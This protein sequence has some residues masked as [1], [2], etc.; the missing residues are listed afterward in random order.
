MKTLT[1]PKARLRE[2]P[3]AIPRAGQA[4]RFLVH[5]DGS[6]ASNAALRAALELAKRETEILAVY[7]IEMPEGEPSQDIMQDFE[8]RAHAF[9]AAAV[10]NA[11]LRGRAIQTKIVPCLAV[12]QGLVQFA[13]AWCP[14]IIFLGVE[15]GESGQEMK[16]VTDHVRSFAPSKVLLVSS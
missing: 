4:G 12:G 2:R 10:T 11:L 3:R 14:D 5:Y 7:C 6:L 16:S 8:V 15:E 13:D 1:Q 9:L